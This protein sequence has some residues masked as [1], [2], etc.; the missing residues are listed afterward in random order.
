MVLSL[1]CT[2]V[3][4][5][6]GRGRLLGSPDSFPFPARARGSAAWQCAR[7]VQMAAF[8]SLYLI[9]VGVE[10]MVMKPRK[11]ISQTL[12]LSMEPGPVACIQS[13]TPK[14]HTTWRHNPMA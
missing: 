4:V 2:V 5:A 9:V 14:T 3:E 7:G 12:D 10:M 8:P 6:G 1:W 13:Q 11:V